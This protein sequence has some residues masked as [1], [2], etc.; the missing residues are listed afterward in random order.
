MRD[1]TLF[2]VPPLPQMASQPVIIYV[3]PPYVRGVILG[4]PNIKNY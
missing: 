1:I 2:R 4:I 3:S